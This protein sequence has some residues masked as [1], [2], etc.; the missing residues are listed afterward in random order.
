[1]SFCAGRIWCEVDNPD[2]AKY[3]RELLLASNSLACTQT[4]LAIPPNVG[5][6]TRRADSDQSLISERSH[7]IAWA[8][9]LV[10]AASFDPSFNS[11]GS[12]GLGSSA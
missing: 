10:S 2:G 4:L 7:R 1:M 3:G 9:K 5:L 11:S 6:K 12:G 8:Q